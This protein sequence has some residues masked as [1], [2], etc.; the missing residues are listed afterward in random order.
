MHVGLIGGTGPAGLGLAARLADVGIRVTVGSRE[1][2]RAKGV[3]EDVLD[4]WPDRRLALV[5][6][7]ND[8]AAR[9]DIV[10]LAT[11]WDAAVATARGVADHLEGKV[12]VSMCNS[13]HQV[14]GEFQWLTPARGSVAESV[15]VVLRKTA[16][17]AAFH[18][19]PARMLAKLDQPMD[20]DVLVCADDLM[21]V[22]QTVELVRT[23]PG[24]RP[25]V[26]GT[27]SM[28]G[29]IE[30]F[31]AVLLNVNVR[32]KTRAA[33]RLT[34]LDGVGDV[35]TAQVGPPGTG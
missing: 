35:G 10:V 20:C 23:V 3:V 26:A 30:A 33:I 32:H 9:A 24:L 25:V 5:G 6:D 15:Q 31:T 13:L 22:E 18:H 7:A 14:S 2:T 4:R 8:E 28:A 34:G 1:A 11:P 12:L 19:L 16:V 17:G 27:L 21:A 29:A